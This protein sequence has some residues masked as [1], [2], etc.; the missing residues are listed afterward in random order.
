M[1]INVID[2]RIGQQRPD[3]GIGLARLDQRCI[4]HHP[5]AIKRPQRQYPP[6]KRG[7]HDVHVA[8]RFG[9]ALADKDRMACPIR[10]V[11]IVRHMIDEQHRLPRRGIVERDA[12]RKAWPLGHRHADDMVAGK[13]SLVGTDEMGESGGV[14][15]PDRISHATPYPSSKPT[16]SRHLRPNP[17]PLAFATVEQAL[18]FASIIVGVAVSDQILSLNRLLR[19]QAPVRW[20]WMLP[21]VALMVLLTNVQIW[22]RIAGE[23]LVKISIGEFLPLL[24]ELIL[25]A[26]LSA[27]SLPDRVPDDGIDLEQYYDQ[28]A[29][30][31]WL[32]FALC[33]GWLQ[34]IDFL[35]V[36]R[37]D[38]TLPDWFNGHF[39]DLIAMGIMI[40][41]AFVRRWWL[42]AIGFAFLSIGPVGWLTRTMS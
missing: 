35:P 8:R 21:I 12:A 37:K 34:L 28:N 36:L 38:I 23:H 3:R 30:Y 2:L 18:V 20:H 24:V 25:L 42:V 7:W 5:S 29:R 4:A 14:Q 19:S 40:G 9:R 13:Y 39:G 33:L 22:W 27:A 1:R 17:N 6:I 41:T 10:I 15:P 31:V 11:A 26:L 32:L 16:T